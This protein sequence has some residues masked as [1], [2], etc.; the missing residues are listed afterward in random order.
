MYIDMRWEDERGKEKAA[1]ISPP[2]SHFMALIPAETLQ[3]LQCLK[4]VFPFGDVFFTSMQ[5]P[6]LIKDLEK[7]I[8]HCDTPET[9]SHVARMLEI[10][11]RASNDVRSCIRFYGD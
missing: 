2:R 9:R 3:E 7:L 4:H 5:I 6:L 8:P 11:R 1:V 10:A